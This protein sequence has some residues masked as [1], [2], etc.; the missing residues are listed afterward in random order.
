MACKLLHLAML[1]IQRIS[2]GQGK[3]ISEF[4]GYHIDFFHNFF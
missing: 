1:R 4:Q 2:F 3:L